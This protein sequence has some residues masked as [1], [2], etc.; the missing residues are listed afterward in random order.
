MTKLR[1]KKRTVAPERPSGGKKES[2]TSSIHARMRNRQNSAVAA[3]AD[4]KAK[5]SAG[6]RWTKDEVDSYKIANRR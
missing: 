4:E 2:N 1:A 3:N 5:P 6:A